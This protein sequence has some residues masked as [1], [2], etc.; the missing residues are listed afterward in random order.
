VWSADQLSGKHNLSPSALDLLNWHP[1]DLLGIVSTVKFEDQRDHGRSKAFH[2][3]A[4]RSL[5]KSV[6]CLTIKYFILKNMNI[7]TSRI[8][9]SQIGKEKNEWF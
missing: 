6:L 4:L 9:L 1:Q 3:N 8:S 7:V 5:H 2:S